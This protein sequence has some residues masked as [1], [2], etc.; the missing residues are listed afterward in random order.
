MFTSPS[1]VP[2]MAAAASPLSSNSRN[3]PTSPT[4]AARNMSISAALECW[5]C[6]F[7][8]LRKA[9]IQMLRALAR[10]YSEHQWCLK[11][12]MWAERHPYQLE[13]HHLFSLKVA[14][15]LPISIHRRSQCLSNIS[16][17]SHND[18]LMIESIGVIHSAVM[19][20]NETLSDLGRVFS[21]HG[22]DEEEDAFEVY[23][24]DEMV[25]VSVANRFIRSINTAPACAEGRQLAGS[26]RASP[27][28]P[29]SSTCWTEVLSELSA[30]TSRCK[31]FAG[32]H[33]AQL[34]KQGTYP[35]VGRN[36]MRMLAAG[37]VVS[38]VAYYGYHSLR[39]NE[40]P[41]Q[42]KAMYEN[43]S[44]YF[45]SWFWAPAKAVLRSLTHVRPDAEHQRQYLEAE[46]DLTA[47]VVSDFIKG[48]QPGISA[49]ELHIVEEAAR[50]GDLSAI[51]EAHAEA[52]K[53][54]IYSFLF[55]P[56]VQLMLIQLQQQKM[57][58]TGVLIST[59]EVLESN[60]FNFKMLALAP[61]VLG[62]WG[63]VSAFARYRRSKKRPLYGRLKVCWRDLSRLLEQA[64]GSGAAERQTYSDFLSNASSPPTRSPIYGYPDATAGVSTTAN[65]SASEP[66][67]LGP[68][69]PPMSDTT[70]PPN[71]VG[72]RGGFGS[73]DNGGM[74]FKAP[75][76]L[77]VASSIASAQQKELSPTDQG[78]ALLIVH[79]MRGLC[80]KLPDYPLL[81][82]LLEDLSD[83]ESANS[84]RHKRLMALS[85]MLQT[86]PI[87]HPTFMPLLK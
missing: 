18:S 69:S 53:R 40:V 16:K 8:W 82:Q 84:S 78:R 30:A 39:S 3:A 70:A 25:F 27:T 75:N 72:F 19:A 66:G 54:P 7:I 74:R 65:L 22:A 6:V 41:A 80:D 77:H 38:P 28:S 24:R 55:G 21:A 64:E 71:R 58:V 4:L 45:L 9:A 57:A 26:D 17:L 47:K 13:L 32:T 14:T 79:E 61:V 1:S 51:H 43:A 60:D 5:V 83:I 29:F 81:P 52:V 36:W 33:R 12:W 56:L 31:A 11:Y 48:Q 42:L 67:Y 76:A 62:M 44:S 59:D 68:R 46:K 34:S 87:L 86:H 35:P 10:T 20:M 2:E 85:R 15:H 49:D 73:D 37:V 23:K 63:S 50:N